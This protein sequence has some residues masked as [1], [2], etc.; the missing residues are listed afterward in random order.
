MARLTLG[1]LYSAIEAHP[2]YYADWQD[3]VPARQSVRIRVAD[4]LPLV[5]SEVFE[6]LGGKELVLDVNADGQ[7]VAFEIT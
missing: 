1:D 6:L 2:R 4:D 3:D 5:R 7:V